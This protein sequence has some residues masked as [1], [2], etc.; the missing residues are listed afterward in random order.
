M[1]RAGR[2]LAVSA[3]IAFAAALVTYYIVSYL[4]M[5]PPSVAAT[6]SA[7]RAR[8]TLQTVASL[9]FKPHPDWVSYLAQNP[10][11]KWVHGTILKL[12]AHSLVTVTV[13]DVPS[14]WIIDGATLN[15]DG[16]WTLETTSPH[17]L[18]VTTPADYAGA[19]VLNVSMSWTSDAS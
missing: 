4:M 13:K 1:N 19:A 2:V 12:P 6:G 10:Q 15:A 16:S 18:T 3:G 9:G 8:L 17:G 5:T 11:G 14:S 7:P